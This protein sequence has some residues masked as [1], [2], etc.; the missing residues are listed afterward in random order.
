MFLGHVLVNCC[1]GKLMLVLNS[2]KTFTVFC[3]Y[4][5]TDKFSKLGKQIAVAYSIF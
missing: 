4:K 1:F 3:S 2:I 5:K